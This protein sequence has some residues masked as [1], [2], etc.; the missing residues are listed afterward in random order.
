MG[1]PKVYSTEEIKQI[2]LDNDLEF[3]DDDYKNMTEQHNIRC[4]VCDYKWRV[5]IRSLLHNDT[6]CPK[7]HSCVK[8]ELPFVIATCASVDLKYLDNYYNRAGEYHNI[9]C[10]RCNHEF[11][12][13]F[14]SIYNDKKKGKK[15][16][17]H[18]PNCACQFH[19]TLEIAIEKCDKKGMI[20]LDNY[21]NNKRE[22]HNLKCKECGHE[23]N[24]IISRYVQDK[25][26]C[27]CPKCRQ[28]I[29]FQENWVR[30]IFE[31]LFE[32]Y[33]FKTCRPKFMRNPSTGR[34][35]ELDGF[36]AILKLAFEYQGI[37]HYVAPDKKPETL[38]KQQNRDALKKELCKAAGI[39][40]IEVPQIGVYVEF[41]NLRKY[42]IDQLKINNIELSINK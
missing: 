18:C 37:Y 41:E 14:T 5:S 16:S 6:G 42:I 26:D 34:P 36:N 4:L 30:M 7:C 9:Q 27:G 24:V 28:G 10:M 12:F 38:L 35:L 31:Q 13:R 40:L 15:A 22:R 2:Y 21:Y 25:I 19:Y 17:H 29:R 20:Y 3:C 8:Y 33:E 1:T 23:I 11:Q 39:T 32:G